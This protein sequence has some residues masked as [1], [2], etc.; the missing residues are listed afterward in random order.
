VKVNGDEVYVAVKTSLNDVSGA[1]PGDPLIA[2]LRRSPGGSWGSYLVSPVRQDASRPIVL[3]A[4]ALNEIYVIAQRAFST[5]QLWRSSYSSPGFN[6]DAA[7]MW[8]QSSGGAMNDPTS[9]KQM[10]NGAT[11]VVVETGVDAQGQYWHNEL[12]SSAPSPS[13][14]PTPTPTPTPTN[15]GGPAPSTLRF[16][17]SA[18]AWVVADQPSANF[19]ATTNL[20][21]D[22]SPVQQTYMRF[23]VAG[24]GGR[25]VTSAQLRVYVS[26]PSSR[27]GDFHRVTGAWSE[28]S[29]TYGTR[30]AFDSAIVASLGAVATDN[31]Y[32]VDVT[33][34]VKGDGQVNLVSTSSIADG[35]DYVSREGPTSLR[36]ELVVTLGDSSPTP[37]PTQTAAP[38]TMT[39][40]PSQDA[41][42]RSGRPTTNYGGATNLEVDNN[43]L[44][45]FL[46][47]F[48]VSGIA[49]RRVTSARLQLYAVDGSPVGGDLHRVAADWKESTVTW[50]NAPAFDAAT[51]A[52]LGPVAVG[53]W[54]EVD[55]TPLVAGDGRVSLLGTSSSNNGADYSSREGSGSFRPRLIVTVAP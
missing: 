2:L 53:N 4:P 7:T 49:G 32:S 18:D 46:M 22:G 43:E 15:T 9:T 33:S 29:L 50:N 1:N 25:A 52:S 11:G 47:S 51:L 28:G 10:V 12:Q 20:K 21:V 8:A 24:T 3:L 36:P 26:N 39:F 37:T 19:G 13:P 42:L 6:P 34:L 23:D 16:T 40:T 55:V 14:S 5:V 48:D 17:P 41:T 27:G 35:A 31:W 30:P 45:R 44:K 38:A 54:Y